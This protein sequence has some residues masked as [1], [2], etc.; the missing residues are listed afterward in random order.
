MVNIF[1]FVFITKH[2]RDAGTKRPP[3]Q[4]FLCDLGIT[5]KNFLTFSFKLFFTLIE[6]DLRAHLK[7][8]FFWSNSYKIEAM[9]TYHI[10]MLELPNFGRM[11]T[12]TI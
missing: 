10:E 2:I 1:S 9:I 4:L 12:S 5:P 7:K 11:T 8:L 3:N 6:L